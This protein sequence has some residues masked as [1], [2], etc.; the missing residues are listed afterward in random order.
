MR[1]WHFSTHTLINESSLNGTVKVYFAV[2]F[3]YG[4]SELGLGKGMEFDHSH[5]DGTPVMV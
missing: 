4:I 2:K 5:M 1:K 3:G